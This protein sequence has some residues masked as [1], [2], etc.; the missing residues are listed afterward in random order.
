MSDFPHFLHISEGW[1]LM[2]LLLLE[3]IL[4]LGIACLQS[5]LTLPCLTQLKQLAFWFVLKFL[6]LFLFYH[7]KNEIQF[8]LYFQFT[9]LQLLD[10]KGLITLLHFE[11][12][13]L[14][15]KVSIHIHLNTG[16]DIILFIIEVNLCKKSEKASFWPCKFLVNCSFLFPDSSICPKHS[17]LLYSI[18]QGVMIKSTLSFRFSIITLT[19]DLILGNLKTS[20]P[21]LLFYDT[22]YVSLPCFLL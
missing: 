10:F 18:N 5:S 22:S 17:K 15:T 16:S 1:G 3:K 6:E 14:E 8:Q 13:F 19:Q 7:R 4:C 20:S 11:L 12:A 2:F 21:F 9:H